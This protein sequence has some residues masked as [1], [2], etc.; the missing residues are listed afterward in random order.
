MKWYMMLQIQRGV[1]PLYNW[2]IFGELIFIYKTWYAGKLLANGDLAK[3][4]SS[5]CFS[6]GMPNLASEHADYR[7]EIEQEGSKYLKIIEN[8]GLQ[9]NPSC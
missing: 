6:R 8:H 3:E 2:I 9:T 1:R 5:L 4:Q 7:E